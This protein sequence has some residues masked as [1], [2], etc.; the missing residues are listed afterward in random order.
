MLA[1]AENDQPAVEL[2][3][4][5]RCSFVLQRRECV[6]MKDK[7]HQICLLVPLLNDIEHIGEMFHAHPPRAKPGG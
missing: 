1:T 3:N 6:C 7:E 4:L 5:E 2:G